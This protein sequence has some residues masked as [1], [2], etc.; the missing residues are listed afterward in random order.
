MECKRALELDPLSTYTCATAGWLLTASRRYDESAEVLRNAI[1]LNPNSANAHNNLGVTY[2]MKGMI[3]EGISEIKRAI[4]ISNGKIANWKSDLALAYAKAGNINEVRNILADLIRI[5]EQSRMSETEIAGVYVS[6]GEK[7]KAME[8]LEKAYER[9]AGYL[10]NIN[11][12]SSFEDL[13]PDPRFQA[14][15]KKI[16]FPDAG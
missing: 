12:D 3:E 16:G 15:L 8:W 2:V 4:E 5:N 9:H 14:L 7:D 6:L 13:R 11:C 1:E 10:V